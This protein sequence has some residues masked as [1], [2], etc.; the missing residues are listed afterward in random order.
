MYILAIAAA[1]ATAGAASGAVAAPPRSEIRSI[2]W[3]LA[4]WSLVI[5]VGLGGLL[6]LEAL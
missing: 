5:T 2:M 6:F 3:Q 1:F 4:L